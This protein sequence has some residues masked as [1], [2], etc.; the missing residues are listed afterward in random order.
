MLYKSDVIYNN[1]NATAVRNT[2]DSPGLT[3]LTADEVYLI[4]ASV[5]LRK[6]V[7]T[8]QEIYQV[9]VKTL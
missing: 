5:D 7:S 1:D 8:E 6:G 3:K 2:E 9:I 4:L